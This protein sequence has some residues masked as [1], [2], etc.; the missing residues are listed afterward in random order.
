MIKTLLGQVKEYRAASVLTPLFTGVEVLLQEPGRVVLEMVLHE[1]RNREILK[2]YWRE[3]VEQ[4]AGFEV[5]Y[6]LGM[7]GIHDSGFE[8]RNLHA[9]TKEE[10]REKKRACLWQALHLQPGLLEAGSLVENGLRVGH[11]GLVV[12]GIGEHGPGALGSLGHVVLHGLGFFQSID[13]DLFS[14]R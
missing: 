11:V 7:R 1:G 6:T 3:S 14:V 10:M 8:T 5:S 9:D 2:E 4:N 12:G 13:L